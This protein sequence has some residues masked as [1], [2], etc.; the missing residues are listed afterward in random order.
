[1]IVLTISVALCLCFLFALPIAEIVFGFIYMEK[2][3]CNSFLQPTVWLVVKGIISVL[4]VCCLFFSN[5]ICIHDKNKIV[6]TLLFLVI[7]ITVP[8]MLFNFIWLIVGSIMFWRDCI[9]I[10]PVSLNILIW[11]AL[12]L[13]YIVVAIKIAIGVHICRFNINNSLLPVNA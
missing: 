11:F 9:N 12:I 1:M 10:Q 8:L 13:G 5:N 7:I 6:N 4:I 2:V 3:S